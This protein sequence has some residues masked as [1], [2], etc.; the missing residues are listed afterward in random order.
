ME[1]LKTKNLGF[2]MNYFSSLQNWDK[3][4]MFSR[5]ILLYNNLAK[6]FN[7]IYIFTYGDKKELAYAKYL[8]NNIIIIPKKYNIPDVIYE[9]ILPFI[10]RKIIKKCD[11]LKTNQNS[12]TIA[13]TIAKVIYGKKMIA[14][15]G[16]IGSEKARL[17]NFPYYAKLYFWFAENVSYFFCDK[18]F[19]STQSGFDILVKKYP[20]VKDKLIIMHN[21]V[22]T[23]LFQKINMEKIWKL[24]L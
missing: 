2:F 17:A 21:F 7:Q 10:Q 3:F 4:G 15:S 13:P 5:E 9:F 16:Y 6:K 8:E 20:F 1:E 23:N 14:R 22:D 19:F 11:I 24:I 18:A 12:G